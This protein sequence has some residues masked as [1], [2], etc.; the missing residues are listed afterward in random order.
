MLISANGHIKLTDF[1]L[2]EIDHKITL[3]E[4]LPT[5]KSKRCFNTSIT[6]TSSGYNGG[7][8]GSFTSTTT[9]TRQHLSSTSSIDQS[10]RNSIS[11][12][13]FQQRTPG[14]ILSLTSN[15]EFSTCLA[16]D[17]NDYS[18]SSS[19]MG[20][21]TTRL[22][23][24]SSLQYP[25]A[26]ANNASCDGVELESPEIIRRTR[27]NA[28]NLTN[29]TI[30]S[31]DTIQQNQYS[32]INK[33]C[34][35][36]NRIDEVEVDDHNNISCNATS[37]NNYLDDDDVFTDAD[38]IN[39]VCALDYSN[40][41]KENT[42]ME[43]SFL[44]QHHPH[45]HRLKRNNAKL[46]LQQQQAKKVSTHHKTTPLKWSK[47]SSFNGL[48]EKSKVINKKRKLIKSISMIH[49]T[50]PG[51]NNRTSHYNHQNHH[52]HHNHH[53]HRR[54][55]HLSSPKLRAITSTTTGLTDL[56]N[57]VKL[58]PS[59]SSIARIPTTIT[60]SS[61]FDNETTQNNLSFNESS[62]LNQNL[63][64]GLTGI[65][66]VLKLNNVDEK[67]KQ[68]QQLEPMN[69]IQLNKCSSAQNLK[70]PYQAKRISLSPIGL[71]MCS[72]NDD[73]EL[74]TNLTKTPSSLL[75]FSFKQGLAKS[76]YACTTSIG[77]G[78]SNNSYKT[79][80]TIRRHGQLM[81][82]RQ[83][84]KQQQSTI[85]RNNH[86]FGTPDY[87]SPE[88]LLGNRHDE[89]VD[90]WALGICL[91][92]FLVGITPFADETP[93]LIFNNILNNEIEW[94]END[95][96]ALSGEAIDCIK[97]LLNPMSSKRFKLNDLKKHKLFETINWDNLINEQAPFIP[98]PDHNMDTFYFD[99][100][101][102][103]IMKCK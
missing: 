97:C 3:A 1:G 55:M 19:F 100:R 39:N 83:L 44:A 36:F 43:T 27:R 16:L 15:I 35:N 80:K 86:V 75:S 74:N 58:K 54:L 56:F 71:K 90:W 76:A 29:D 24:D 102:D 18:T 70:L 73:A 21:T 51:I 68:Q 25:T 64:T 53:Q 11:N 41:N 61:A 85:Q 69:E 28:F 87:L 95:D 31:T 62:I 50:P 38:V 94:P 57:E 12:S 96:E 66:D 88:L 82:V 6:T 59:L 89:S 32:L 72:T 8:N 26:A 101:N 103:I 67:Q 63:N 65:F 77:S 37:A 4:I 22:S 81:T 30:M 48:N 52:H 9:T 42:T 34:I 14:Q 60:Q 5:P 98:Q 49:L 78:G 2:S 7:C 40:E 13:C 33:N 91:Y 93:E 99:T 47:T 46:N 10:K 45:Q 92:E 84:E 17:D 20:T 23:F 79:P